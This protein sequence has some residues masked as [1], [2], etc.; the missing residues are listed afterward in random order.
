M[1]AAFVTLALTQI[2]PARWTGDYRGAPANNVR[3]VKVIVDSDD[4]ST[5]LQKEFNREKWRLRLLRY[6]IEE[7]YVVEF[8]P[9]THVAR[10]V[11]HR[12]LL[13]LDGQEIPLRSCGCSGDAIQELYDVLLDSTVDHPEFDPVEWWIP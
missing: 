2:D 3:R 6:E 8:V 7:F 4:H 5:I 12:P 9:T 10:R 13:I 11:R 1:F